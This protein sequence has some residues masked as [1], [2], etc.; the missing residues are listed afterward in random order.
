MI[1]S[2]FSPIFLAFGWWVAFFSSDLEV[3][4]RFSLGPDRR[5]LCDFLFYFTYE[6]NDRQKDGWVG[7]YQSNPRD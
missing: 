2:Y 5:F 7:K 3:V 1:S 6:Q 4:E